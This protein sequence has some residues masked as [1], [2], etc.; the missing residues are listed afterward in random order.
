MESNDNKICGI[1]PDFHESLTP[2]EIVELAVDQLEYDKVVY[3]ITWNPRPNFYQYDK[4]GQNDYIAQWIK[5]MTVLKKLTRVSKCFCIVPEI[6]DEG[7]L[8]CHGWFHMTDRIKWLKSVKRAFQYNGFMKINKLN[9]AIEKIDY[10]YKDIETTKDVLG[11]MF[12][13]LT[14]F[15]MEECLFNCKFYVLSKV[16]KTRRRKVFLERI[17][18]IESDIEEEIPFVIKGEKVDA[19]QKER[20]ATEWEKENVFEEE[21]SDN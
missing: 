7:K 12:Q 4:L 19:I 3:L 21:I 20:K 16:K 1:V 2:M 6:S 17:L 13:V 5:M 11:H 14:H 9:T 10:Y 18:D 8:H 15:T